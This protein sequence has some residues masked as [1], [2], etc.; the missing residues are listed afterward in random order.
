MNEQLTKLLEKQENKAVTRF[1]TTVAVYEA[2]KPIYQQVRR[3]YKK[4]FEHHYTVIIPEKDNM[5]KIIGAD[6]A[7]RMG[8]IQNDH[9]VT[10]RTSI[11]DTIIEY[12]ATQPT[13]V[14]IEGYQF[15]VVSD[16]FSESETKHDIYSSQ[17]FAVKVNKKQY[18]FTCKS[19][20]ARRVLLDWIEDHRRQYWKSFEAKPSIY[21]PRFG[22]WSSNHSIRHRP[23]DSVF[24]KDG[25]IDRIRTDL[26]HFF[27]NEEQYKDLGMPYHRGYLF[28]GPPGTGKSSIAQA[29]AAHF[30]LSVYYLPLAAVVGD[31]N[32]IDL[33]NEIPSRSVLLIEDIDVYAQAV[34][35]DP[36]N[37]GNGRDAPTL[38]GL[39]NSLDGVCTPHGLIT[40]MTTNTLEVLDE[41]VIRPGRVDLKEEF[42]NLDLQQIDAIVKYMGVAD[43]D[44]FSDFVGQSP[45]ALMERIKQIK[46]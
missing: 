25:Q 43:E 46:L 8:A 32:L 10:A 15:T 34:S 5:Y 44:D 3:E 23:L 2:A 38:A 30:N 40:I 19:I 42:T 12:H 28:Y 6:L 7:K 17:D 39:L 27:A 31:V 22:D 26:E 1:L 9:T 29:I 41:A 36:E 24:G 33:I 4:R 11:E 35:R 20:E 16:E 18:K 37:S 21:I 45:A 13:T 14:E